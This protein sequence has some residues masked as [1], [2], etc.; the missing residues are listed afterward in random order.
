MS[1]AFAVIFVAH[2]NK[3]RSL[4]AQGLIDK[5]L[6]FFQVYRGIPGRWRRRGF[7]PNVSQRQL[8]IVLVDDPAHVV[9]TLVPGALVHWLF[10]TP[11]HILQC[12]IGLKD[13]FQRLFRERV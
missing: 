5:T 13:F 8:T 2:I 12:T 1:L 4:N 11:H 10:L 9:L 6:L 7:T 3:R